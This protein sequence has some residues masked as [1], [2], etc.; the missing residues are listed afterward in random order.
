MIIVS[1][2]SSYDWSQAQIYNLAGKQVLFQTAC[3]VLKSFHIDQAPVEAVVEASMVAQECL[4]LT[5]DSN[6]MPE[7]Y[8]GPA[9]FGDRMREVSFRR[10][11]DFA[12][13]ELDGEL[14][15]EIDFSNN[16]IHLIRDGGFANAVNVQLVTGPAMIVLL[17]SLKTYCLH[18][19]AVATKQGVIAITAESGVGKS[20]L[21]WQAGDGWQQ[22]A[23]DI[24]PI[25]YEK[26]VSGIRLSKD[27]PQLKLENACAQG[28]SNDDPAIDLILRLNP[29]PADAIN[30]RIMSKSEAMLQFVRHTVAVKLFDEKIM[31]RHTKFA[32]YVASKVPMVELSYPRD[33][34]QL[35]ELREQIADYLPQLKREN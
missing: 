27:F 22:L 1:T 18:A 4:D 3:P 34:M 35:T 29:K 8:S 10:L 7:I 24:L 20:T 5:I 2:L 32:N 9:P 16:H 30:F 23:D 12:R 14:V 15:C 17:A 28:L 6:D 21:A 33:L 11:D 19:S 25:L 31:R 26:N 13:F